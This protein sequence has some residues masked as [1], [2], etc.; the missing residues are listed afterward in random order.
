MAIVINNQQDK[1]DEKQQSQG[2]AP[3]NVSGA[4]SASI[5]AQPTMAG[6]P[7]K[8]TG[9]GRF[10][11]L[12]RYIQASGPG[13]GQRLA[14]QIGQT[15]GK[16]TQKLSEAVEGA[17]SINPQL[18]AERQRIAQ[19]SG[20]AQQVQQDPTQLVQD[21]SKLQSFTQLRTGTSAIPQLQQQA[22]QAFDVAQGQLGNVQQLARLT[23]TEPG[24]FELLRQSLGRPSYTR[25]QQRL[26][27]LLLQTGGGNTLGQLQRQTA[28][29]AKTG[30][31]F[32]GQ[33]RT[34]IEKGLGETGQ[35]AQ[36]AKQ[37]LLGAL[38]RMDDP[39][40]P[41]IDE[42]KDAGAFGSLQQS[43][44]QR[45]KDYIAQQEALKSAIESGLPTDK[46]SEEALNAIGLRTGQKLYDIN[47]NELIKPSFSAENVT[48][49]N[50]ANQSDLARYQALAQLAGVDPTYLMQDQLGKATGTEVDRTNL[51]Q[52]LQSAAQ[53]FTNTVKETSNPIGQASS[54][55]DF[56]RRQGYLPYSGSD[57]PGQIAAYI[58]NNAS[59]LLNQNWGAM[60]HDWYDQQVRNALDWANRYTALNPTRVVNPDQ[61]KPLK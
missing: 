50:I 5:S 45:Q 19:A 51:N 22:M 35:A 12:Q 40:T 47:L 42:S 26:D 15:V 31:Q 6:A 16:Q 54:M 18:D 41:D 9:S 33:T 3:V 14:G 13:A 61:V 60:K 44:R 2:Q 8:Q 4:P 59:A 52:A 34:D 38:G 7:Q 56:F 10:T 48:E 46:F 11:N 57:D 24:R 49:Q 43:L 58:K 32:L 39:S 17:K 27:Q 21:P 37:Q 30:E 36:T 23:G 55:Y 25:G 1:E 20:F 28:E 29:Q 53:R